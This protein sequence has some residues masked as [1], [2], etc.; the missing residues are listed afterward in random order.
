MTERQ[1]PEKRREAEIIVRATEAYPLVLALKMKRGMKHDGTYQVKSCVRY[2]FR[3]QH[4][5]NYAS[6]RRRF[7]GLW[8]NRVV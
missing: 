6:G 2:L 1:A 7:R 8:L 5:C 4:L 3:S